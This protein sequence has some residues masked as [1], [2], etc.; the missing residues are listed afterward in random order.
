MNTATTVARGAA[1]AQTRRMKRIKLR[2][3][4]ETV[5]TLSSTTL[6]RARGGLPPN[7][8]DNCQPSDLCVIT[9]PCFTKGTECVVRL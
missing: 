9:D 6:S 1:V 3:S 4:C 8:T 7:Y 5:R 2:L